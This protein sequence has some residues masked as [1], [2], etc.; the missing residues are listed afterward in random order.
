MKN[1]YFYFLFYLV[2]FLIRILPSA[3]ACADTL[4][5]ADGAAPP[6]APFARGSS[7][8]FAVLRFVVLRLLRPSARMPSR[9]YFRCLRVP[10]TGIRGACKGL[11]EVCEDVR[12]GRVQI[13]LATQSIVISSD[14]ISDRDGPQTW[15]LDELLDQCTPGSPCASL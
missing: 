5:F 15:I 9:L 7:S 13:C 12:H 6:T 1:L 14:P 10:R 11:L 4:G 2:H 8:P 3:V